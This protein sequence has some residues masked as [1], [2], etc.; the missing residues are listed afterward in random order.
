MLE[1]IIPSLLAIDPR[2]TILLIGTNS[3]IF[4]KALVDRDIALEARILATGTL[5]A[6][7]ISL[8]IS[9]CDVMAQ[10]YPDGVSTRRTT[11]MAA[12]NHARAIVTTH[13]AFTEPLWQQSGAAALTECGNFSDFVSVSTDIISDSN[14]RRSYENAAR[15]L[16]HSRFDVRHTIETLR[17]V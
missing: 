5:R 16:Y 13:G 17:K 2:I 6:D 10:P 7:E 14:L 11:M 1:A 4:R 12:L 8:A 3:E 15:V 9:S